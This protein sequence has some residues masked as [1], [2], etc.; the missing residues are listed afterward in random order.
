MVCV[1]MFGL[2]QNLAWA[3]VVRGLNGLANGNFGVI[4][5]YLRE[6]TDSTNQATT[7]ALLGFVWGL[8]SMI[9]PLMGGLLTDPCQKFPFVFHSGGFFDSYRYFLPCVAPA[10]VALCSIVYGYFFL[11]ESMIFNRFSKSEKAVF[12]QSTQEESKLQESSPLLQSSSNHL[13]FFPRENYSSIPSVTQVLFQKP[14]LLSAISYAVLSFF[15]IVTEQ[16]FPIWAAQSIED[17]GLGLTSSFISYYFIPQGIT[18]I[19][20]QFSIYPL[21]DR[22]LGTLMVFRMSSFLA[23]SVPFTL[24]LLNSC[25]RIYGNDSLFFFFFF[26]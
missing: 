5:V 10:F 1:L 12:L 23:G 15:V 8:G 3:V 11:D 16:V 19:I 6:I 17:N 20:W 24:P 14:V 13:K 9:G 18:L 7:F 26:F 21:L 2:S 22:K 4:K 25:A